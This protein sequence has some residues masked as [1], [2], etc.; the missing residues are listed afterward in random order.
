MTHDM[1]LQTGHVQCFCPDAE[2]A[3]FALF[4]RFG[5]QS[6]RTADKFAGLRIPA[7]CQRPC[8]PGRGT[9]TRSSPPRVVD[10]LDYGTPHPVHRRGDRGCG[11]V[12]ASSSVT[13][14]YYF[15]HIKPKPAATSRRKRRALSARSAAMFTRAIPFRRISSAPCASTVRMTLSPFPERRRRL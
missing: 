4:Q 7:Q 12:A 5:F 6:G 2:D 11:T 14:D 13:Y 1:I 8:L 15:A 9:R 3:P 10:A